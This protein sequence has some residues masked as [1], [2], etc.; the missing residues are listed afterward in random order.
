VCQAS[1]S[2]AIVNALGTCSLRCLLWEVAR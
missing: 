2:A 1:A